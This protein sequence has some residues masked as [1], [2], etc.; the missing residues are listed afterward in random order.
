M[1]TPKFNISAPRALVSNINGDSLL[2]VEIPNFELERY[3][4]MFSNLLPPT[5]SQ[6]LLVRRRD[7]LAEIELRPEEHKKVNSIYD[8]QGTGDQLKLVS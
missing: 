4:V 2:Q 5:Q 1:P 7:C 3:S 6:S 8:P